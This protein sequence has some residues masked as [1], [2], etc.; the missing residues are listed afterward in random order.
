MFEVEMGK[1]F[2]I[3]NRIDLSDIWDYELFKEV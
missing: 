2:F 3:T 1:E